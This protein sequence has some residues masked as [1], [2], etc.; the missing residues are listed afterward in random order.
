[1][2][3]GA[4]TWALTTQAKNKQ[5]AAQT[6]TERTPAQLRLPGAYSVVRH[7]LWRSSTAGGSHLLL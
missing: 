4:K 3:Y 6:D 2:T 5:A 7:R 1:M